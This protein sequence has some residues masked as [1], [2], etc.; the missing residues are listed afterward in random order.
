MEKTAAQLK[1]AISQLGPGPFHFSDLYGDSWQ[2]LY[3]GDKVSFG[4]HFLQQVRQ[5]NFWGVEDTGG[6]DAQGRI[7]VKIS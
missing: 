5:G 6:K 3:I 2:R 1:Q 4:R 7:Y